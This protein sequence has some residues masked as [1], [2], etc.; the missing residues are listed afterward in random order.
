MSEDIVHIRPEVTHQRGRTV[1]LTSEAREALDVWLTRREDYMLQTDN[2]YY[3][4]GRT[5]GDTRLFCSSYSGMKKTWLKLFDRV[6]GSR[7]KYRAACTMHSCRRYFRTNAVRGM[8]L[9]L[10]EMMM[11]HEG[12]LTKS[13]RRIPQDE[14]RKQFHEGELVLFITVASKRTEERIVEGVKQE[15]T[16]QISAQDRMIEKMQLEMETLTRIVKFTDGE[17]T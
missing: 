7:G 9:D 6:D 2:K 3:S 11:G 15:M 12:Y 14:A 16:K 13:Y 5:G 1:Y 4:R 17:K 8:G 10:V